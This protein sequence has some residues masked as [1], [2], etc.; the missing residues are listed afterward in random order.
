MKRVLALVGLLVL[1]A[2]VVPSA[3]ARDLVAEDCS[4]AVGGAL[5]DTT[6]DCGGTVE[7]WHCLGG[8]GTTKTYSV[9][10][11]DVVLHMCRPPGPSPL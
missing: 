2:L 6:G 11:Y 5:E 1:G 7:P 3:S 10:P 9:G 4:D 8:S